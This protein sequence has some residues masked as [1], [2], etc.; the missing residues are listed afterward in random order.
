MRTLCLDSCVGRCYFSNRYR[1]SLPLQVHSSRVQAG[2][3]NTAHT[4][5]LN[6]VFHIHLTHCSE[7]SLV[8]HLLRYTYSYIN[9][10]HTHHTH[11][12]IQSW[13]L[14]VC[15]GAA[16]TGTEWTDAGCQCFNADTHKSDHTL[17]Q[18]SNDVLSKPRTQNPKRHPLPKTT[19]HRI[20]PRCTATVTTSIIHNTVSFLRAAGISVT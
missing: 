7:N 8:A 12:H 14:F 10:H 17:L 1:E 6:T 11:S 3:P 2:R 5:N 13:N 18:Q 20:Q 16:K 9:I 15:L 4:P 19:T